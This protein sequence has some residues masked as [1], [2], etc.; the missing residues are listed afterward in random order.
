MNIS[1]IGN[2]N[3]RTVMEHNKTR[4]NIIRQDG[5]QQGVVVWGNGVELGVGIV[6]EQ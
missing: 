5:T 4:W 1:M 6:G 2:W 3:N